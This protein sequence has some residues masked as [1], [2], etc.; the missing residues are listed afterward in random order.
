MQSKRRPT[1]GGV[2]IHD[3]FFFF[4]Q[5]FHR[6]HF[7]LFF[8]GARGLGWVGLEE[9]VKH[10]SS[11]IKYEIAKNASCYVLGIF[12]LPFIYLI[13]SSTST[14]LLSSPGSTGVFSN[15]S[16]DNPEGGFLWERG[17]ERSGAGSNLSLF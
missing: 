1:C 6:I 4:F 3:F 5:P 9:F 10:Y 16:D 15:L 11:Y 2:D 12:H 17:E 13:Y 14:T 8:I 7:T